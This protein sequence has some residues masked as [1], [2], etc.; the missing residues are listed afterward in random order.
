LRRDGGSLGSFP[1]TPSFEGAVETARFAAVRAGCSP[2]DAAEFPAVVEPVWDA[3]RG[4]PH[5]EALRAVVVPPASVP[6]VCKISLSYFHSIAQDLSAR[7]VENGRL[8]E[9]ELFLY[10]ITAFM[11]DEPAPEPVADDEFQEILLPYRVEESALE[12]LLERALAVGPSD[13]ADASF[14]LPQRTMSEILER[15]A[16]SPNVEVGGFLL[17]YVRR[18]AGSPDV[19]VEVTEQVPAMYAQ[20]HAA[21]LVFTPQTW[22]AVHDVIAL[23]DRGELLLGYWHLHPWFCRACPRESRERCAFRHPFYSREDCEL[24][25]TCFA[26]AWSV[27][28]LVSDHGTGCP[29]VTMYGW[30]EGVIAERGF[31][32]VGADAPQSKG[33]R[34][35]P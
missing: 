7:V 11:S 32:V 18:A 29:S 8:A 15:S 4:E 33:E 13:D 1:I 28:L 5:V 16:A 21:K 27:G 12:P 24:H 25:A 9:G 6:V 10:R 19:F 14:L 22:R 17:G 2:A 31:H 3:V 26:R 34:H 23:R 35:G 30:R 20:S